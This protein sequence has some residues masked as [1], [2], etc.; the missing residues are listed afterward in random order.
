MLGAWR[1]RVGQFIRPEV[2]GDVL[3]NGDE[4]LLKL[5]VSKIVAGVHPRPDRSPARS[6][7][8]DLTGH[9]LCPLVEPDLDAGK[10]R[11]KVV[12]KPPGDL[13]QGVAPMHGSIMP[14][15]AAPIWRICTPTPRHGHGGSPEGEPR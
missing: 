1:P 5:G 9:R 11:A 4:Q 8:A 7:V 3:C 14:V 12:G 10:A 15:G 2:V 13:V 6:A